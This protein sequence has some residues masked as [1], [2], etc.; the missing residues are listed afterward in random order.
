VAAGVNVTAMEQL[1]P[2]AR[3]E[4]QL[5][6]WAKLPEMLIPPTCKANVPVLVSVTMCAALV[7]ANGWLPKSRLDGE[8]VAAAMPPCPMRL[9]DRL[10]LPEFVVNV[11]LRVPAAV[12]EKVTWILQL[13]PVARIELQLSVS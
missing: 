6:L 1:A 3:E 11:P 7:V 12:G 9:E 8:S 2:G 4:G 13:A 5:L 10:M